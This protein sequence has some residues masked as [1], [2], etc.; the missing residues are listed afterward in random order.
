MEG[1]VGKGERGEGG[2]GWVEGGGEGGGHGEG[3]GGVGGGWGGS[4]S[5]GCGVWEG[6]WRVEAGTG[7]RLESIDC[8]R[9]ICTILDHNK[10]L[11]AFDFMGLDASYQ[12]LFYHIDLN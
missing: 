5:K 7:E 8:L 12:H 10:A 2:G 9:M 6:V 1:G 4:S 3:R 11:R